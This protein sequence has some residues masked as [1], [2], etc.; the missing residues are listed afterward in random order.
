MAIRFRFAVEFTKL[1]TPPVGDVLN[2]VNSWK[3]A[4]KSFEV[5]SDRLEKLGIDDLMEAGNVSKK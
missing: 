5:L 4:W 1:K 2:L 3:S